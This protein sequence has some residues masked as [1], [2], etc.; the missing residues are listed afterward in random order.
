[1]KAKVVTFIE[2]NM[3]TIYAYAYPAAITGMMLKVWP[4]ISS[5]QYKAVQIK[6]VMKAL[7]LDMSGRLPQIHTKYIYYC[8]QRAKRFDNECFK[9]QNRTNGKNLF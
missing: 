8:N 2:E 9:R 5:L 4:A 7:S 6:F 3:K 1:M